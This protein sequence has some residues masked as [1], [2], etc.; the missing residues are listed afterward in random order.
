[1]SRRDTEIG[2]FL[3]LV[4]QNHP[5]EDFC[6]GWQVVFSKHN[7]WSEANDFRGRIGDALK[8]DHGKLP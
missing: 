6:Q 5:L 4:D 7:N 8:T 3:G 2:E 1:M